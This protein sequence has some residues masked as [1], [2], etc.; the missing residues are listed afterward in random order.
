MRK[1]ISIWIFMFPYAG[2][3]YKHRTCWAINVWVQY[4]L[5]PA[6]TCDN[7]KVYTP[8]KMT[9][10][11]LRCGMP[12]LSYLSPSC[13]PEGQGGCVCPVG[14]ALQNSTCVQPENCQCR[15]TDNV[16][17]NPGDLVASSD[18]CLVWW[19]AKI[20]LLGTLVWTTVTTWFA[21]NHVILP[22]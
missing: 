20:R 7:G 8:V 19:V 9:N 2:F 15:G 17:Y 1:S 13:R 22:S 18:K 14:M 12:Q 3:R 5:I 6:K 4:A 21:D 10:C 11:D 16:Y